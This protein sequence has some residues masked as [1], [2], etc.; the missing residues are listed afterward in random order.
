MSW[1]ACP[2]SGTTPA[3]RVESEREQLLQQVQGWSLTLAKPDL[4]LAV[5]GVVEK[6]MEAAASR[7]QELE[8]QL[9]EAE[10]LRR[11]ARAVVDA[12][13][14]VDRLNRLADVLAE[15][16][17]SRANL[18]LSLHI[19]AIR[20]FGDGRV[21]VRTCKLGALAGSTDLLA[22]P[23]EAT[24]NDGAGDGAAMAARP[25]RRS[26]RRVG[27]G[28]GRQA[29]LQ[30]AAHRAADVDRFAGLDPEWF[31]E[32]SFQVQRKK[33]W[34]EEHAQE[35]AALRA[36]GVTMEALAEHFEK[37]KPTVRAALRHARS[38]GVS[39]GVPVK[40]RRR[41]WEE[42]HAGEVVRLHQQGKTIAELTRH[43]GK[44]EPTIRKALLYAAQPKQPP[45]DSGAKTAEGPV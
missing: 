10:A 8:G 14:V 22:R 12:Q 31:W 5:R 27:D 2:P 16:N 37:S 4:S 38:Q 34:A 29:E 28:E 24:S 18:E 43:F 41:R 7:L 33:S 19:E 20:C 40:V 45:E 44:S 36:Q 1:T 11:Q 15:H 21:V 6:D 42:D 13:R 32:D 39:A 30:A 26:V 23:A 17:P 35:V 9:A 25:R 3:R